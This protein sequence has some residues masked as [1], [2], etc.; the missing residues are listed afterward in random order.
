MANLQAKTEEQQEFVRSKLTDIASWVGI[1]NEDR[2][3]L[4]GWVDF[5]QMAEIVD[6]LRK[7]N[8]VDAQIKVQWD[9][10]GIGKVTK[11]EKR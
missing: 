7:I 9:A 1:V 3:E 4:D 2:V 5:D 6:Y 11:Y 8:N 10:M